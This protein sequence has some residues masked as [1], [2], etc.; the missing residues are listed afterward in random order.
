MQNGF[1]EGQN[2][3]VRVIAAY[4]NLGTVFTKREIKQES[5]IKQAAS[6]TD[7]LKFST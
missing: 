1:E 4:E 7:W 5:R 3:F 2:I 6:R